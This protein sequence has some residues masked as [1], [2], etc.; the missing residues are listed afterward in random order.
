MIQVQPC[1]EVIIFKGQLGSL[2]QGFS[3]S[4]NYNLEGQLSYSLQAD[5]HALDAV[6]VFTFADRSN[7][8]NFFCF[9]PIFRTILNKLHCGRELIIKVIQEMKVV[10][11]CFQLY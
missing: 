1:P 6:G 5:K 8:S 11:Y 4:Q 2:S 10:P 9:Y 7:V 3:S